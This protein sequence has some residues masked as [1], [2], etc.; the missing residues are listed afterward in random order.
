ML[1]SHRQ[2]RQR[3]PHGSGRSDLQPKRSST[4]AKQ[5][6]GDDDG[7]ETGAKS[8]A[9]NVA[10]LC[11][12]VRPAVTSDVTPQV[13]S[14]ERNR[15]PRRRTPS[16]K[17]HRATGDS[18]TCRPV[19]QN[20]ETERVGF[21]P[22]RNLRPCRFSRPVQSATLPPLQDFSPSDFTV[23]SAQPCRR[24]VWAPIRT[25]PNHQL[26][27]GDADFHKP[28]KIEARIPDKQREEVRAGDG[29]THQLIAAWAA[30]DRAIK[31][32]IMR[33]VRTKK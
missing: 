31:V 1:P 33:M 10:L 2:R 28:M 15:S 19:S 3:E 6:A 30:L 7:S 18:T 20:V 4:E 21:E 8:V 5:D 17:T 25:L 9:P 29:D 26:S 13:G 16:P 14:G 27:A 32:N 22:T 24:A 11:G 12:E 23:D